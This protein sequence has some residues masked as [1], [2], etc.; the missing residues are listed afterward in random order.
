[1]SLAGPDVSTP[2]TAP[3]VSIFFVVR[4]L[5]LA[6]RNLFHLSVSEGQSDAATD[7]QIIK[8]IYTL[9]SCDSFI[10]DKYACCAVVRGSIVTKFWCG[11]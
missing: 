10:L 7:E 9:L 3:R 4:F 1:M 8:Q 11:K 6:F 2:D 5:C